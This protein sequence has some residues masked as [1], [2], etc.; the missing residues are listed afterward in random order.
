MRYFLLATLLIVHSLTQAQTLI[1]KIKQLRYDTQWQQV[2]AIPLQFPT[3]HPQGMVRIGKFFYMSSVEVIKPPKNGETGEGIGHLFKMDSTGKLLAQTTLGEGSMYHPGGIDYDGKHIWVPV[4]EYRPNSQAIIYK[5]DPANMLSTEVFRFKEHIGGI[6]HNTDAH[7]LF[8][9]S[10]GS[11]NF[12]QWKLTSK[13][14]VSNASASPQ[15]LRISNPS[16]YIDYQDCHYLGNH[17]MLCSGLQ[18]YTHNNQTIRIGGFDLISLKDYR[19]VHQVPIRLWSPTGLPMTSNPFWIESTADGI[20]TY[21]LP[22]DDKASTLF[23]YKAV[24]KP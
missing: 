2:A 10:W 8:G 1:D 5:V 24:L 15:D 22:D 20:S 12:Y 3:Y 23:I 16:F 14:Q 11:R 6:V 9:I 7:T 4:A 19:P 17:M 13:G 21:F 18:R